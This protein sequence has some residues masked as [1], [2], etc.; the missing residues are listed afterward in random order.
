MCRAASLLSSSYTSGRC[1]P[2]A[3]GFPASNAL[4]MRLTSFMRSRIVAPEMTGKREVGF[5][6]LFRQSQYAGGAG[7]DCS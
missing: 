2:T 6:G 5:T 7:G 4:R 3:C 1:F